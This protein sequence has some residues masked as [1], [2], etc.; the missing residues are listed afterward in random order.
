MSNFDASLNDCPI[1]KLSD[2]YYFSNEQLEE[3]FRRARKQKAISF[4]PDVGYWAVTKYADTKEILSNKKIFSAEITQEPLIPYSPEVLDLFIA[5]GFGPRPTLSN[6]E[7]ED[8]ARIRLNTLVGFSP[9]RN[10]KLEPYIRKL[11]NDAVDTFL[12]NKR[13]D[14]LAEMLYELPAL[15]LFKLLGIPENDVDDI[16]MWSDSRLVLS[17]GK[18]N[19]Q[20]QLQA[21][22]HICDYWD[23]CVHLVEQRLDKPQDDL[24]SDLIRTR[25]GDDAILEVIDIVNIVYGLLFAGHETTTNMSSNAVLTLLQHEGSWKA[26]TKEPELIPNA[27]EECMRFRSSVVAWR[28]MVKEDV[29]IDGVKLTAGD[30]IM[31]FLPSANR[32]E[33]RF[34][35]SEVFDIHRKEARRH[36]AFGFGRH[37][38]LGAALARLELKII[39]EELSTRLPGLRLVQDQSLMP[40]E[41][42]Q[43]RG[44][45]ELWVEWD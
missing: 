5:R 9:A 24:P 10:K 40:V 19:L 37:V 35:D 6:N 41:A 17:F 28:R 31:L 15:V 25:N 7:R 30:R 22:N 8:H 26:I 29:E 39:L 13:A 34:E 16:K 20:Q 4:L 27:V 3:L 32:D 2:T 33:A 43:F 21:G 23:Y 1:S 14:L 38:C 11:V 18:P 45:E 36:V 44:P 42:V 12:P